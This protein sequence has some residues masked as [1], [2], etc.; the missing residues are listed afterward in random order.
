[1]CQIL[2][3]VAEVCFGE[4]RVAVPSPRREERSPQTPHAPTSASV[5]LSCHSPKAETKESS[6]QP[7]ACINLQIAENVALVAK[8]SAGIL[9]WLARKATFVFIY[10]KDHGL[11]TPSVFLRLFVYIYVCSLSILI[12]K[13]KKN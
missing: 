2:V 3:V 12:C 1:M 4:V 8:Y 11:E 10:L 9:N 6:E 5:T 7:R 13:R